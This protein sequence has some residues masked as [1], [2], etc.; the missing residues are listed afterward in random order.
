MSNAH[1]IK[2]GFFRTV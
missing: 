2:E 1:N